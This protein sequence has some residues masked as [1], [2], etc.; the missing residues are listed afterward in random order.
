MPEYRLAIDGDS[1]EKFCWD[2]FIQNQFPSYEIFWQRFVVPIT[3]RPFD[4]HAKTDDELKKISKSAHDICLSQLHYSVLRHLLKVYLILN[5]QKPIGLDELTDGMV[6]LGGALDVAFELLERFKNP[7]KY[8]PWLVKKNN[9]TL[10]SKNAR[11][12]WQ[13]TN[14][15]PLQDIRDY[16]NHLVHGRLVPSINGLLPKIGKEKYYLDWRKV[17]DPKQVQNLNLE[18]FT[19]PQQILIESWNQVLTYL[20]ENWKKIL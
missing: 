3:N 6:R 15:Y 9:N 5:S 13:K 17:T 19:S 10:G 4:I 11:E 20:E 1:L 18:D 7:T 12:N 8:D 14:S 2:K 16:R